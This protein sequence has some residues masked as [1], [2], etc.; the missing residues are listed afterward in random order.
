LENQTIWQ[1]APYQAAK[2]RLN[3]AYRYQSQYEQL[4]HEFAH[5]RESQ[6]WLAAQDDAEAAQLLIAYIKALSPY[7][8]Q[9]GLNAELLRWCNSGLEACKKLHQ[10]PSWLLLLRSEAQNALGQWSEAMNSIQEAIKTSQANDPQTY[11]QAVL[12]LGRLQLNRGDYKKALKT[13]AC[14]EKLLAEQSDYEGLSAVRSEIAAYH[15]NRRELD[16]ALSYYLEVARLRQQAGATEPS[17]HTLLMLGV[18]YR[19]RR[20]Y[21]QAFLY[22]QQLLDRGNERGIRSTIAT[23]AHH[24]A[25]VHLNRGELE[26]AS[27]LCGQ[28]KDLYE[29]IG[30]MRGIA[31][32]YEQLGLIALAQ[33]RADDA[34]LHLER[35]LAV[36]RQIGNREG[37]A[38]SLRRL[39]IAYL[40]AGHPAI[41]ARN[42]WQSLTL[43]YNL[44]V[45]SRQRLIAIL[46]ELLHWA[47]GGRRWPTL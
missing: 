13:L 46:S 6:S 25:W 22:L 27:R 23:A 5:F 45:L 47:I 14:A 7:L 10:N 32:A 41:A 30:D 2:A 20:E 42:L 21:N 26:Q 36:R 8:R 38:S 40:R 33:S 15:L 31:D 44:G 3:L 12:A 19:K 9:R 43:Y 11:A 24:L 1:L 17:D 35:S 4:D 18:V 39:A 37:E 34:I 28:A 16:K 29:Q